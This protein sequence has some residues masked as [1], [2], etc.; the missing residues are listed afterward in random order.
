MT[1]SPTPAP[2][3]GAS[4]AIL[5]AT[6][7][8][9]AY[10]DGQLASIAAQTHR[11]WTLTAS[12]DGSDDATPAILAAF[13]QSRRHGQVRLRQGPRRG[14]TANFLS[15]IAEGPGQ[16]AFVALSDQDDIWLPDKLAR[17]LATLGPC[18]PDR[19]ALYGART[20]I[21]DRH[22]RAT[23]RSPLFTRPPSFGNAL[24]Q[25]VAGGN[26]MVMNAAAAA[27][28]ARAASL[29]LDLGCEPACH[30]WWLYQLVAGCGGT[31]IYDPEPALL[32]RQHGANVIGANGGA[33]ARLRRVRMLLGGR[34]ARWTD[35]NLA[36][37]APVADCLTDDARTR[38]ATLRTL[39]TR[40]GA[41][42]LLGLRRA[43]LTRQTAGGTLS[44]ALAA[45]I[46]RL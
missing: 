29:A 42:A 20:I 30:D 6:W 23:G 16:A 40:R 43:G 14:S 37:L 45:M 5:M 32:Y 18:D 39:R 36:A 21:A 22:G 19:P 4:V 44:L 7:N 2:D 24:V 33:V 46:G 25:S 34:F 28:A 38:I 26:T 41:G 15:L 10:L 9:A 17:A 13:A 1:D 31:V 11:G 8:G 27:L 12:D 35:M 3:D